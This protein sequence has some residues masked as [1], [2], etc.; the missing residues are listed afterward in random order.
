MSSTVLTWS[1]EPPRASGQTWYPFSFLAPKSDN[2]P[3]LSSGLG[4]L[5]QVVADLKAEGLGAEQILLAGF[6]QGACLVSEY[7][8]SRPRRFGGAAIF[9][10]GLPGLPEETR[11]FEG[12]L[13]GTPVFLG[14]GDPD[15]H[16]PWARVVETAQALETLGAEVAVRRYPGMPHTINGEELDLFRGMVDA[17]LRAGLSVH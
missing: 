12:S 16:V 9:T 7:L 13:A 10:G 6:S 3:G 14:S 2:E 8:A 17:V 11:A 15:L 5:D 4:K 1:T